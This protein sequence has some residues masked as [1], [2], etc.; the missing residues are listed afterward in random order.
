M[1]V[2]FPASTFRLIARSKYPIPLLVVAIWGIFRGI[3]V[4]GDQPT[5]GDAFESLEIRSVTANNQPKPLTANGGVNLGANAENVSFAF[6]ARTNAKETPIRIRYK[7]EGYDK[8][9]RDGLGEM[10]FA[11]RFYNAAGDQIIQKNFAAT[12]DS[13]GWKGTLGAS[14]LTHRRET[15]VVPTRASRLWVV[16]TSAGPPSSVGIYIVGNF[17]ISRSGSN[18]PPTVLL[19]SPFARPTNDEVNRALSGWTRDGNHPSMANIVSI[20]ALPGEKAFAILDD[21]VRSH[22]EWHNIME[23]A[24]AVNPGEQIVVEWDE[25]FSIGV[26]DA[27]T[28]NYPKL[29]EGSYRFQVAGF[30]IYGNPTGPHVS[31]AV[32]APPPLWRMAWFWGAACAS[33]L[34]MITAAWR[35]V[36]W[37]KMQREMVRLRSERALENERL[38]IAQDLHDD[39]GARVTEI[40]IASALAKKKPN[41][42][43]TASADFDRISTLSRDLVTALYE[44]VWAVNPENDNLDALGNYLC[45]M[46]NHLCEQAQLPCRFRV[47]DL[48][49]DIQV[50]SQTRHNIIMAAKEAIHNVIKHAHASELILAVSFEN[51]SMII[52]VEDNGCGFEVMPD[53]G[54]NGLTNMNRRLT[55]L[56]GTCEIRSQSGS[57]TKVIMR[58]KLQNSRKSDRAAAVRPR[59]KLFR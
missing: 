45:Q 52:S 26:G 42:P 41:L 44:T 58:L 19:E 27:M 56:G 4:A 22:A 36:V 5:F 39:F 9:W 43:E 2:C 50:S 20:G 12:G 57:G 29:T 15:I 46:A 6:G 17:I 34:I 14:S 11:I 53:P 8:D 35:Y 21:D 54:G 1:K 59:A 47:M 7:L 28:V 38:R 23:T 25:A 13:P 24:A 10:V 31:I 49:S 48:P 18:S 33:V 40:S 30:D 32:L 16:I 55:D 3:I 51:G 37:R